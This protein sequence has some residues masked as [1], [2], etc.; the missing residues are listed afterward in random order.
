[1]S[2]LHRNEAR[3]VAEELGEALATDWISELEWAAEWQ[4]ASLSP[5]VLPLASPLQ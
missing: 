5:W 1:L 2:P 3:G 4:L